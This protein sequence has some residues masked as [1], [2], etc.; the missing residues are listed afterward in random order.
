MILSSAISLQD[1]NRKKYWIRLPIKD[2][3]LPG[4]TDGMEY[5]VVPSSWWSKIQVDS[6]TM[7]E[8]NVAWGPPLGDKTFDTSGLINP[9]MQHAVKKL[10]NGA[11][12]QSIV[13]CLE[14]AKHYFKVTE[15][16]TRAHA[17]LGDT[18]MTWSPKS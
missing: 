12:R 18:A 16:A 10:T 8:H 14:A 17:G 1:P 7:A 5:S 3:S 11:R 6:Q 4:V 15:R 9:I 13:Q 2:I